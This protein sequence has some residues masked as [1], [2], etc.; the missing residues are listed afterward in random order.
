MFKRLF[1]ST[2]GAMESYNASFDPLLASKGLTSAVGN[3]PLV[4]LNRISDE[5]G[6]N[7][8]G[9]A[10][11][12]NPGGSVKDRAALF[13]IE[14][15]EKRGLIKPGGT[16]V[17]GTAGNTGIGLAHVARSKG[18]NVVI[19]MPN[20]QAPS[21]IQ[22]LKLLGC[23]VYPVPV[24]PFDNPENFN[25]QARRHAE[26]LENAYWTN[27]FDNL[28][29]RMAHIK[30]TGPEIYKQL[31]GKVHAFT[32]SLGTGGTWCGT[33]RYLKTQNPEIKCYVAEPPGSCVYSYVKTGG[34]SLERSGSSF[35]EGI[36]QGR[37]TNNVAQDIELADDAF[38]IPDEE[39]IAML[40]RLLDEEGIYVGGTSALNVVAAVRAAKLLPEQSNIVTILADSAH[41]YCDRIFSK[42]WLQ[43]KNLYEAIPDKLRKYAILE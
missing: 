40:Y 34:K 38:L 42:S 20:T 24:V 7:I 6:R 19:Y 10:E 13:F 15:A 25:H 43:S 14:E 1:S 12:M 16:I 33:S 28:D 23:E 27:Q 11:W 41:K 37:I 8:Y 22:T 32:C 4:K 18:Y 17:E 36:G 29:N 39:T 3:T 5:I 2:K 26:R 9:K 21:K 35:T 30:M 31:E